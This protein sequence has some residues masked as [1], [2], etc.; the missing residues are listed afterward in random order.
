MDGSAS[1]AK[2]EAKQLILEI[3]DKLF[4]VAVN[5]EVK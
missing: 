2:E 3:K 4:K 1:Q 5:L